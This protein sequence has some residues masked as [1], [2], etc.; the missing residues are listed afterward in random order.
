MLWT[1][2]SA[3]YQE[4]RKRYLT[5]RA[6]KIVNFWRSSRTT[7][8]SVEGDVQFIDRAQN[9]VF[10]L[11]FS[12]LCPWMSKTLKLAFW[13]RNSIREVQFMFIFFQKRTVTRLPLALEF[14]TP[15]KFAKNVFLQHKGN[16][17]W[18][19]NQISAKNTNVKK[20]FFE[21][22]LF[23]EFLLQVCCHVSRRKKSMFFRKNSTFLVQKTFFWKVRLWLNF[24][25]N[26]IFFSK[27]QNYNT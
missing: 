21:I 26:V 16:A 15:T 9:Y 20:T 10:W 5:F 22:L 25:T 7:N 19:Q 27:T 17:V 14:F 11:S 12:N 3:V 13:F 8:F 4:T 6:P 23:R 1:W 18:S 24:V 2:V